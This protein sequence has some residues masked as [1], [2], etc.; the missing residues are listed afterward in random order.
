MQVVTGRL[1]M[2]VAHMHM[3][4]LVKEGLRKRWGGTV[5]TPGSEQEI[6]SL[7]A[8][9]GGAIAVILI[10]YTLQIFLGDEN[11]TGY[12]IDIWL[13]NAEVLR[14]GQ[15][16]CVGTN[17][18]SHLVLNYDMWRVMMI[19]QEKIE[20]NIKWNNVDSHIYTKEYRD[21]KKATGDNYSI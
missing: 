21:G 9:D 14:M 1:R 20:M 6:S 12:T 16:K 2:N 18:A 15:D 8:E 4:S 17:I 10:V 13:D 11:I 7:W 5:T 3:D 19:L